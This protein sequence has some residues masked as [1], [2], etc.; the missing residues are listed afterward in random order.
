MSALEAMFLCPEEN[1]Q[2]WPPRSA[3]HFSAQ[4]DPK[5]C[6]DRLLT[7]MSAAPTQ[8]QAPQRSP[9]TAHASP[10]PSTGSCMPWCL[11]AGS[12]RGA[13][14]YCH[15][16][17]RFLDQNVLQQQQ[18]KEQGEVRARRTLPCFTGSLCCIQ[19][20]ARETALCFWGGVRLRLWVPIRPGHGTQQG[21]TME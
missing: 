11:V 5:T 4:D 15:L 7:R 17:A 1:A 3:P 10:A 2:N 16:S 8:P 18:A 21:A 20:L 6:A 19:V 13:I 12:P 14:N 9:S